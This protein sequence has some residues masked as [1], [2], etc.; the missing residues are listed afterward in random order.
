MIGILL[1][2]ITSLF[3]IF[4]QQPYGPLILYVTVIY[5][6]VSQ[7]SNSVRRRFTAERLLI[8]ALV[9]F[10]LIEFSAL[11]YWAGSSV[12]PLEQFGLSAEQLELDFTFTL[13]PLVML[14]MLMLLFSWVW[15]PLVKQFRARAG[16]VVG[17]VLPET[18]RWD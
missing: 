15:I 16:H 14:M 7:L 8:P 1:I 12:N 5:A 6:S 4:L 10:V 13:F 9:V 17:Y 11:Y 3:L 2:W 18:Y